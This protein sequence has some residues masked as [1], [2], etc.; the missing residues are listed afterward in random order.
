MN[1]DSN[2]NIAKEINKQRIKTIGSVTLTTALLITGFL[3]LRDVSKYKNNNS[4]QNL[5]HKV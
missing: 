1:L 4:E 3:A 2:E 5:L